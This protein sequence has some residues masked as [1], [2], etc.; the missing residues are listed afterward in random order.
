MKTF[1]KRSLSLLLV[2]C[3]V[4]AMLITSWTCGEEP[5]EENKSIFANRYKESLILWYADE[6]L[7]DYLNTQAV[8]YLEKYNVKVT[9]VLE[10]GLDYLEHMN[11]ASVQ[12][13]DGPD[14]YLTQN[15]NLEK[16]YLSGL[17][18]PL[19]DQNHVVNTDQYPETAYNSVTYRDKILAYPFYYETAFFLFNKTYV[20]D[21][22][23]SRIEAQ[24]D[25]E[26]GEAAQAVLDETASADEIAIADHSETSV[27][28]DDVSDEQ[29]QDEMNVIIPATIDDILTFADEYDAPEN[30]EAVFKWDVSDIFYNYF[31]VGNY[32]SVG[33]NNGDNEE[34]V[35]LYNRETLDCLKV[36][37]NLNQFF[38][39]DTKEVTYEGILQEFLDGKTVFT[40]A[41]T[42]AF[43][44]LDEAKM[45][46]DFNYEYGVAALPD[47]STNLKSRGLSVTNCIAINGYTEK[48]EAAEKFAE[49]L[50]NEGADTLYDRTGK[51]AARYDVCYENNE[52]TNAMA[53]YEKSVPMTKLMSAQNFWVQLE[54]TFTKVWTGS[55][56]QETLYQMT[57][58][59]GY[60]ADED[61]VR[62][63]AA[64]YERE[65]AEAK[66]AAEAEELANSVIVSENEATQNKE[67][68]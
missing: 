47:V 38:S 40:I 33:G 7:T 54:I 62:Q 15:G 2:I 3:M 57:Q 36:Y 29:I 46:G 60:P 28:E 26:E 66:A 58:N 23:K 37:Q 4:T 25:M 32:I 16:A 10:S 48:Q 5:G 20:E 42:D 9:P 43:K 39:I 49:Y 68:E 63:I 18:V 44:K 22:A 53:E 61:T 8:N 27:S 14:L 64:D 6:D 41:T 67:D 50:V 35:N 1:E 65:L 31:M 56:I 13:E 19:L 45:N 51:V 21:L 24:K 59:C 17:A 34:D 12:T 52:I 11:Q 30:V 55:D